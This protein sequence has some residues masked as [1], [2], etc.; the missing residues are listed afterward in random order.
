MKKYNYICYICITLILIFNKGNR[1]LINRLFEQKNLRSSIKTIR[2]Q[3]N[4]LRKKI[5]CLE[6]K[7]YYLE[8]AI[9]TELNMIAPGEIEY[10]F[11]LVK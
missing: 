2:K 10:R 8:R 7:D 6:N 11:S 3:N 5:F 4:D 1:V 9:H